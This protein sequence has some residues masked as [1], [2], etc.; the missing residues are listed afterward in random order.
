M[1]VLIITVRADIGGGPEHIF[2]LI[3]NSNKEVNFFVACPDNLPYF[4]RYEKLIGNSNIIK[5]PYRKFSVI[6]LFKLLRFIKKKRIDIIH[7]HGKGGGV[8]SRL[9]RILVNVKIIHT[10]HGLHIQH[11]KSFTRKIYLLIEKFFSLLTDKTI[12]V[13]ESEMKEIVKYNIVNINKL[14]LINNGVVLLRSNPYLSKPKNENFIVININRFNYQKNPMLLL[15]IVNEIK[16][17]RNIKMKF[18]V[19][20][21]GEWF[22]NV[23]EEIVKRNLSEYI[24]LV[25]NIFDTKKY[26]LVADCFVSTSRWEG[27]SLSVL[28]AMSF[29]I[30]VVATDVVGNKSLINHNQNGFLYNID[31]YKQAVEFLMMLYGNNK[32]RK[33]LSNNAF[34]TIE[35]KYN[36]RKMTELTNELYE[37]VLNEK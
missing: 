12:S 4:D 32:L 6:V 20:G 9:L 36:V 33:R 19:L 16:E 34:M 14:V 8:Y 25:G 31:D 29:G 11:Y 10:F 7:S 17:K 5:I 13:S 28:E 18:I 37:F 23:K 26:F 27:M 24:E 35:K 30:P 21:E 2:Q 22:L 1:N 15:K 3:K